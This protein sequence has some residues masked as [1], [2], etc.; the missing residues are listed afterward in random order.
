M[1]NK[2]QLFGLIIYTQSALH[3]SGDYFA[4]HQERLTVFAASDIVHRYCC[5]QVLTPASSNIG[6]QYQML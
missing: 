3:V 2:M 1:T 5:W 4:H 6:G